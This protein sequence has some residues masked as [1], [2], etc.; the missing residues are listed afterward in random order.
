M[1]ALAA[2]LAPVRRTPPIRAGLAGALVIWSL[3]FV[4]VAWL[5]EPKLDVAVRLATDAAW[6]VV[7]LGLVL[8]ALAGCV[9]GLA[10]AVPGRE[11]LERRA[12]WIGVAGLVLTLI[13][14][15]SATA[16][17]LGG[18]SGVPLR[19]DASCFAMGASIGLVP[20]AALFAY[21]RR[22]FV[23]RPARDAAL[24]LLGS[25]ALGGLTMQFVCHHE[26][27]RHMLLGH[28]SIPPLVLLLGA[29][30]FAAWLARRAS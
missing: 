7:V 28:A 22:G 13:A 2:D 4:G 18:A 12:R 19:Q 3:V 9:A 23:L 6:T 8:A 1:D 10:G 11:P 29:V 27:A 25:S 24:L 14:A 15:L 20:A 21:V 17:S 30:P 26:G 16:F 5:H